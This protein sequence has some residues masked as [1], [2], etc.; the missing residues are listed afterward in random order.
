M[1]VKPLITHVPDGFETPKREIGLKVGDVVKSKITKLR[2][3]GDFVKGHLNKLTFQENGVVAKIVRRPTILGPSVGPT[4]YVRFPN[5]YLRFN[6]QDLQ[7]I[8]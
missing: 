4:I 1:T 8:S 5:C 2:Y 3:P 6:G 7:K